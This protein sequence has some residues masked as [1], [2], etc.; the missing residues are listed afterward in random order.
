MRGSRLPKHIEAAER[1][2]MATEA[3]SQTD[4]RVNDRET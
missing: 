1:A 2:D 4:Q 3:F